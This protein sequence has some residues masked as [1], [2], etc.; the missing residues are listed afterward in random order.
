MIIDAHQHFWELGKFGYEWLDV[1]EHAP[2]KRD[3][4]PVHLKPLLDAAGVDRTVLV[5][6]QH[7]TQETRWFLRMAEEHEWIAGVVGW[8]DLA[9]PDCEE[10]LAE[11]KDQ[12]R[13][14][15]RNG[16]HPVTMGQLFDAWFKGAEIAENPAQPIT[17][18]I[19]TQPGK[20]RSQ[21]LAEL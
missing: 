11:F 15:N 19:P 21:T 17:A 14:L 6:T 8:I 7:E 20:T 13:W 4:V 2:L 9:S 18:A 3:F 16:Y 5:Q 12:L 1:P 10:A